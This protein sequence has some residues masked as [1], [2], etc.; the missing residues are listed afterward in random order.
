[1]VAGGAVGVGLAHSDGIEEGLP[2]S[3]AS[4]SSPDSS[5]WVGVV[6]N[7]DGWLDGSDVGWLDGSDVGCEVESG[8]AL[9]DSPTAAVKIKV[10]NRNRK[11]LML[12]HSFF[13]SVSDVGRFPGASQWSPAAILSSSQH[14]NCRRT[15]SR[16]LG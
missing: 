12:A 15:V 3:V 8:C 16:R 4:V 13:D 14:I 6:G 1:M 11:V 2:L 7:E 9:S 10:R 5:S